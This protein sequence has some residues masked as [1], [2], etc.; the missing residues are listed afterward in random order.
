MCMS[1]LICEETWFTCSVAERDGA[2]RTIIYY[3]LIKFTFCAKIM[4]SHWFMTLLTPHKSFMRITYAIIQMSSVN[5]RITL[6]RASTFPPETGS[7]SPVADDYLSHVT[8]RFQPYIVDIVILLCPAGLTW[9]FTFR[10]I[11]SLLMCETVWYFTQQTIS[12]NLKVLYCVV[13]RCCGVV[14]RTVAL[15]CVVMRASWCDVL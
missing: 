12:V 10:S 5:I 9:F 8:S 4:Y 14:M 1:M 6:P 7:V 3:Y 13:L 15:R 11:L 2:S